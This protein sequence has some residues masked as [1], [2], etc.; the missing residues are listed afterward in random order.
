M[1]RSKSEATIFPAF[2]FGSDVAQVNSSLSVHL[3]TPLV[4]Y[5]HA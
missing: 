2:L 3:G 5:F 4:A 1:T